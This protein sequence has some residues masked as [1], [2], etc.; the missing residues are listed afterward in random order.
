[1][2]IGVPPSDTE[3]RPGIPPTPA[4]L[5][6]VVATMQARGV[7]LL[8]ASPCFDERHARRVAEE[9]G[10]QVVTL[11]HQVGALPGADD[12][13]ATIDLNVRAVANGLSAP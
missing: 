3:P 8:L 13:L 5:T 11:A 9:T 10:A 6:K 2:S 7:H 12:Y 1:M 4:H